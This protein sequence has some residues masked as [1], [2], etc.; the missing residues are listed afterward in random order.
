MNTK[1]LLYVLS[2]SSLY[3]S[4]C[5]DKYDLIPQPRAIEIDGGALVK[6]YENFG[7]RISGHEE[8]IDTSVGPVLLRGERLLADSLE[9]RSLTATSY[10]QSDTVF[11][12]TARFRLP[13]VFTQW[14]YKHDK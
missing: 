3:F 7:H 2:V 13:E 9:Q 12:A 4:A 10:I 11:P 5:A 8:Q 1:Q 6:K 14:F